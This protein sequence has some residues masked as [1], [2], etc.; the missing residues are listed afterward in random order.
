MKYLKTH[1]SF[2]DRFFKKREDYYNEDFTKLKINDEYKKLKKIPKVCLPFPDSLLEIDI[3]ENDF[4][5]LPE[6]PPNLIKLSCSKNKLKSLPKL[7]DSLELI[8]CYANDLTELPELPSSLI[9]LYASNN[10]LTKLPKL[11]DSLIILDCVD[12]D[13]TELPE[14]TNN[15]KSVSIGTN[16]NWNAPIPYNWMAKLKSRGEDVPHYVY[17]L[18]IYTREQIKEFISYEFQK[19]F[20][21]ENPERYKDLEQFTFSP[22]GNDIYTSWILSSYPNDFNG[23]A[24][25][26]EEEFDYL[27]NGVDMGLL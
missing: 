22:L 27:F 1:E 16:N 7:P 6:L 26:I 12:N 20:L 10:Y 18:I 14:L 23:Y 9:E 17:S 13:L 5:E 15:L 4:T 19:K 8:F 25:G 2:L 24:D 3:C 21:T 11:P